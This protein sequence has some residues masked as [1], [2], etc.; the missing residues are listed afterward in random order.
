MQDKLTYNR[1]NKTYTLEGSLLTFRYCKT[2]NRILV[3]VSDTIPVIVRSLPYNK[4][5]GGIRENI[6]LHICSPNH[7]LF[8]EQDRSE[9]VT[10][11]IKE[12]VRYLI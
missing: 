11:L 4:R 9:K 8:L 6:E 5:D 7:V 3:L 1:F 10:V 12:A 2:E